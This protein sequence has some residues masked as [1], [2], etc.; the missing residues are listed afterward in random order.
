MNDPI[1]QEWRDLLIRIDERVRT[2]FENIDKRFDQMEARADD[3]D[4]RADRHDDRLKAVEI[5]L[6]DRAHLKA[7]FFDAEKTIDQHDT[8][9][10]TI[11]VTASNAK[12]GIM[13][14]WAVLG[15]AIVAGVGKVAGLF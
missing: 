13:A 1:P 10:H 14:L 4:A 15:S 5:E 3:A 11:E 12:T 7:R 8:R 6:A 9:L 2:G